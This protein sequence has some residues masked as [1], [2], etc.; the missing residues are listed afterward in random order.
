MP[1]PTLRDF[2][3]VQWKAACYDR[4]KPSTRKRMDS[5]LQTQLL[6][7]FGVLP[8]DRIDRAAV[9]LWFDCYSR[10][11]PGGA[12]QTLDVLRQILNHA[13][14]C[15][16]IAANPTRGVI[17]NPRRKLTRFLSRAEV[18]RLHQALAV[19]DRPNGATH[20]RDNGAT[21]GCCSGVAD[22]VIISWVFLLWQRLIFAAPGWV[23]E[24]GSSRPRESG[25]RRHVGAGRG[26]RRRAVGW[27]RRRPTRRS[28]GWR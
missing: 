6:P 2:V 5:A 8:L 13:I 25:G 1:A 24:S 18:D 15:G 23:W 22:G 20:V 28:R 26:W 17:R 9:H 7:A 19:A 3:A 27:G 11:A 16:Y 21:D 12:N 14:A 10:T 4:C